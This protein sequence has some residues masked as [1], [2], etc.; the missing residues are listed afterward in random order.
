MK[1]IKPLF[2]VAFLVFLSSGDGRAMNDDLDDKSLSLCSDASLCCD[3]AEEIMQ[4]EGLNEDERIR[5]LR[6]VFKRD[7]ID[8]NVVCKNAQL[9]LLHIAI[10]LKQPKV[11]AFL[12]ENGAD[13][14]KEDINGE[15]PLYT[16]AT[17]GNC[18][19]VALLV[20]KGANINAKT[21]AGDT[22]LH[23]AVRCKKVEIVDFLFWNGANL[24]VKNKE[25][26]TALHIAVKNKSEKLAEFLV[27][28]GASVHDK[29]LYGNTAIS[30]SVTGNGLTTTKLEPLSIK[31]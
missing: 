12:I 4:E 19:M 29:D 11:V 20:G 27:E 25:G 17:C 16:A 2:L 23:G 26:D 1:N 6:E 22:P 9:S 7:G 15:T 5:E 8:A 10:R 18:A 21:K 24:H 31:K 13:L 3:N 28:K 14:K 30:V